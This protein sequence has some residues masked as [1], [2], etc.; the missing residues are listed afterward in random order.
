MLHESHVSLS[1]ELLHRLRRLAV[2]VA[3]R[4]FVALLAGPA[5]RV[6]TPATRVDAPADRVEAPAT[7]EALVVDHV[8]P[9][10]N[11]TTERDRFEVDAAAFAAAEA[12][13]RDQGRSWLGF[14][15]S[16]PIGRATLSAIDRQRLW[17]HC[18]QLVLGL[19]ASPAQDAW[20]RAFRSDGRAWQEL[21]IEIV[22]PTTGLAVVEPA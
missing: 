4:E 20:L 6:D 18:L 2:A 21:P 12:A 3:P 7:R 10:A 15:H 19:A 11:A 8:L 22:V 13:L 16:H 1:P 14:V 9:I 17:P 5:N